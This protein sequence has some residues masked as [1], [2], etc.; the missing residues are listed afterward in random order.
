MFIWAVL[1]RS[2][3]AAHIKCIRMCCKIG[4]T[5]D[6]SESLQFRPSN[7]RVNRSLKQV[8]AP[9]KDDEAA[10]QADGEDSDEEDEDDDDDEAAESINSG[11]DSDDDENDDDDDDEKVAIQ[12]DADADQDNTGET[13]VVYS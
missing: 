12:Q 9:V 10:E 13:G 4:Q 7:Q 6:M 5:P 1:P 8:T 3:I 11:D 2:F